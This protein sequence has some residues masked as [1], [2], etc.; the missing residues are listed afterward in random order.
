MAKKLWN[1]LLL[2]QNGNNRLVYTL[3]MF[4]ILGRTVVTCMLIT[5]TGFPRSDN[6]FVL[7]AKSNFCFY[8]AGL[9]R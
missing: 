8:I 5:A 3:F 2:S 9:Q 7:S 1:T 4:F 6:R